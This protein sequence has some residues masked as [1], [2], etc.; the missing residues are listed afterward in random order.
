MS[1]SGDFIYRT[2]V[3]HGPQLVSYAES[4]VTSFHLS[5]VKFGQP[6]RLS[7]IHNGEWQLYKTCS[8]QVGPGL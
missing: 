5:N 1:S 7:N 3:V 6:F 2:R 8:I 4:V